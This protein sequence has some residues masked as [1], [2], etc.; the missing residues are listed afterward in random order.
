MSEYTG[1]TWSL[2]IVIWDLFFLTLGPDFLFFFLKEGP[3]SVSCSPALASIAILIIPA[4]VQPH[5][6]PQDMKPSS[7]GG[8]K[9]LTGT[10]PLTFK[11][12]VI[13]EISEPTLGLPPWF[14][15]NMLI[16]G[17]F[18][19]NDVENYIVSCQ[20]C[21]IC[22]NL[23]YKMRYCSLWTC[24][25]SIFFFFFGQFTFGFYTLLLSS[26]SEIK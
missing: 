6:C 20:T 18:S 4:E 12:V 5:P 9:W 22:W 13:S 17:S 11:A 16:V 23:R 15:K 26:E 7:W 24:L 10:S 25:K 2:K 14:L 8:L 21:R 1:A 3:C 19:K